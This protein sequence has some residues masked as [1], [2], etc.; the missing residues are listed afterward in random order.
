MGDR[1]DAGSNGGRRAARRAA[2]GSG[3]I[4]RITADR[5]DGRLGGERKAEFR[6]RAQPERAQASLAKSP[7]QIA[8]GLADFPFE[9]TRAGRR[10]Q[11]G[12]GATKILGEGR[13]AGEWS[14]REELRLLRCLPIH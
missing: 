7:R 12:E 2:S 1:N 5:T 14:A 3:R 9:K 13:N 8:V 6:A 11:S 4:Q 10:R